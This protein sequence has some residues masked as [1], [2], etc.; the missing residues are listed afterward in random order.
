MV[1]LFDCSTDIILVHSS[2]VRGDD[3]GETGERKVME[4]GFEQAGEV[5]T[6]ISLW[7]RIRVTLLLKRPCKLA[8]LKN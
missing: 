7:K 8:A 3:F 2:N 6:G 1:T 4:N 5:T